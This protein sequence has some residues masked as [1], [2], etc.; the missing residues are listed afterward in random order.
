MS[1]PIDYKLYTLLKCATKEGLL[2]VEKIL[3]QGNKIGTYEFWRFSVDE[4]NGFPS[5]SHIIKQKGPVDYKNLFGEH[6]SFPIRIDKLASVKKAVEYAYSNAVI[7]SFFNSDDPKYRDV[8]VYIGIHTFVEELV[9]RYIHLFNRYDLNARLFQNI[10]LPLENYIYASKF[11][12]DFMVPILKLGFD[13]ERASF[14]QSRVS[15]EKMSDKIQIAR[16][17]LVP[18]WLWSQVK[19]IGYATHAVIFKK[20]T[21]EN[22]NTDL[23]NTILF[24]ETIYMYDEPRHYADCFLAALRIVTD[25]DAG[26]TQVL[27]K[28]YKWG[29]NYVAD[30]PDIKGTDIVNPALFINPKL[31]E[32]KNAA[33]DLKTVRMVVKVFTRLIE[34]KSNRLSIAIKRLNLSYERENEE[35]VI[36]DIAIAIEALLSDDNTQE[37]THKLALRIAALSKYDT[38]VRETPNVIFEQVKKIYGF[39]SAVVHGS[40]NAN[41]KREIKLATREIVPSVKKGIEYVSMIIRVLLNYPRFQNPLLIDSE[42]LLDKKIDHNK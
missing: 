21:V 22:R 32:Q 26:Y 29:S 28:P 1:K 39:R 20:W 35:D 17:R 41:K 2:S 15:I 19:E 24:Y 37:I 33:I 36:I 42:L 25:C 13:F 12:F 30:L 10:Y 3:K 9:D 14:P 31:S 7:K 16:M 27:I 38:I 4:E 18:P 5:F 23:L 40:S 6:E 11:D 34:S 8:T